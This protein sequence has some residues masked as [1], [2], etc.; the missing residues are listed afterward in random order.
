MRQ[1]KNFLHLY[2]KNDEVDKNLSFVKN[3]SWK[4]INFYPKLLCLLDRSQF[5][6]SKFYL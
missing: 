6:S 5:L 1:K 4:N 2:F 3:P